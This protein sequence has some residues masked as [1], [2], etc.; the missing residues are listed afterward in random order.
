MAPHDSVL[1]QRLLALL[2][3]LHLQHLLSPVVGLCRNGSATVVQSPAKAVAAVA[4]TGA[5]GNVVVVASSGRLSVRI[6]FA[7]GG[8]P[9][10]VAI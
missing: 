7:L 8:A 9:R 6:M 1:S 10:L 2:L 3:P 5:R 4:A